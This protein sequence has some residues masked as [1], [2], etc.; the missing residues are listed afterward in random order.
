MLEI[1]T[2]EEG[3]II[4]TKFHRNLILFDHIFYIMLDSSI[5]FKINCVAEFIG[6]I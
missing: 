4:W 3:N 5:T 2:K 6:P 1:S